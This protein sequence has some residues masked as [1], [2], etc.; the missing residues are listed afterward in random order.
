MDPPAFE[1]IETCQQHTIAMTEYE[2]AMTTWTKK[3]KKA[4]K[5]IISTISPSIMTYIEDTKDP[6][7]MWAILEGWYRPKIGLF[8]VSSNVSSIRSR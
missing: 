4:R 8:Y 7:E 2:T 1:T 6:A 3:A 5:L